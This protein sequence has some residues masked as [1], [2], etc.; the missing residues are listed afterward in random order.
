MKKLEAIIADNCA[1]VIM[2]VKASNLVSFSRRGFCVSDE[3]IEGYCE[4]FERFG[5]SSFR[6]CGCEYSTLILFYREDMLEKH[7]SRQSARYILSR[8]GYPEGDHKVLLAHLASRFAEEGGFPHEVGLFLGYPPA[9]VLGFMT[10][11]GK[12]CK[13]SG[14]WKVYSCVDRARTAFRLYDRCREEVSDMTKK[15]CGLSTVLKFK[16]G[17]YYEN[18]DHLLVGNW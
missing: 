9:D 8:C 11:K 17:K 5:I 18:V 12:E 6:L 2:G 4:M 13:D 15:G 16:G 14:Y 7:L 1:P 3:A 10:R